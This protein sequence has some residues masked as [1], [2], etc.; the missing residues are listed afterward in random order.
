MATSCF[1]TTSRSKRSAE[2][3]SRRFHCGAGVKN[4]KRIFFKSVRQVS[5]IRDTS[6]RM[7]RLE[8][9]QTAQNPNVSLIMKTI[10]QSTHSSYR[11]P[12][13]T[14]TEVLVTIAI[15]AVLAVLSF[16]GVRSI[17]L[18]ASAA[19]AT[20][21]LRQ[22]AVAIQG[23]VADKGRYPEAWDFRGGSGG[24]SWSW[25]IRDQ[26]G[27]QSTESWPTSTLLHPRHGT[28]GLDKIKGW[29]RERLHHFSASAVLF[30][31]VNDSK[32]FTRSANVTNPASIIMLGDAPLIRAG[33][34]ASGCD[35]GY[36][37][38]RDN[39]V[40]GNPGSPVDKAALKSSVEFWMKGKAHFLFV[41]GHVETLAPDQVLRKH[42]QP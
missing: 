42:F 13:F 12:G 21:S 30:Q 16:T 22:N 37:S 23:Y 6:L 25:Q 24:G 1:W 31:D 3:G 41:D 34:P 28:K 40:K 29:D 26:L 10:T 39:A 33:S 17:R 19:T 36:W 9:S 18:N 27:Y 32:S 20:A 7:D 4:R 5:S 14:L 8:R 38:L 15:I 2:S 35:A 11:S